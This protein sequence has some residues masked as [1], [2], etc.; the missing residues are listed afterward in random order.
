MVMSPD[1]LRVADNVE[2]P[3]PT[4]HLVTQRDQ[5]YGSRRKCCEKCGKMCGPFVPVQNDVRWT[6]DQLIYAMSED[7]CDKTG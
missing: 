6:D 3:G 4:L 5:P 2:V 1:G 7:R